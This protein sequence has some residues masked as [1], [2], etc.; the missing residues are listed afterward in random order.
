MSEIAEMKPAR[1]KRLIVDSVSRNT[2]TLGEYYEKRQ[3]RYIFET[4]TTYDRDLRRI[5]S[6][7]PRHRRSPTA[8]SFLRRNRPR[9]RKLV[10]K[11]TGE[12]ELTLDAF[13]DDMIKRC[14]KLRLHAVG[15]E[16]QLR[17][18]FTVLLTART[19]H[20][21]YAPWRRQWFAL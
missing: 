17:N 10:S 14:S 16:R 20:A 11:W 7:D 8:A 2:L 6:E 9:I 13:L 4:P 3:A 21:L 5:F 12:H 15:S 18:D 19:V 1:S